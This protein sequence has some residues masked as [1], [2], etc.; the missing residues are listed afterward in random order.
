VAAGL[1]VAALCGF[2]GGW[3]IVQLELSPFVI[4]LGMRSLER[5]QALVLPNKKMIYP[6]DEKLFVTTG[7]G[8]LL[9]VPSV[10]IAMLTL[11]VALALALNRLPRQ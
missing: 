8:S 10:V 11:G 2:V 3:A 1:S 9:G 4:T 7:G 5:G 6:F